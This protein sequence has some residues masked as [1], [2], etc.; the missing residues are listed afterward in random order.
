VRYVLHTHHHFD[1][2]EGAS[3]FSAT[4]EVVAHRNFDGMLSSARTSWPEFYGIADRNGNRVLDAAEVADS[5]RGGLV[6]AKD[7]DNDGR[8]RPEEL[9]RRV[10]T[11][12][13]TYDSR[14][15]IT[16]G[17]QTVELVH[18]GKAH[19]PDMTALYFP[20]ERVV[21]VADPPATAARLSLGV[22]HRA[23]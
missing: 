15:T 10:Q 22:T 2:A 7:R 14:R 4:A 6:S 1:R 16:L 17:G 11:P 9:Y 5:P 3:V 13:T 19:A 12:E 18:T 23:T 21:F 8:V 20:A